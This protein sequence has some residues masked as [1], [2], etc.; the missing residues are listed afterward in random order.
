MDFDAIFKAYYSLYRTEA[1]VPNNQD[2]EYTV[3]LALA[4]EAIDRWSSYDN[5]YWKELFD[6]NLT[7]DNAVDTTV[8]ADTTDYDAPTDMFEASGFVRIKNGSTTVRRYPILDAQEAQMKS[9]SAYYAYFTGD[10]NNGFVLHLNPSVDAAIDGFDM[11]YDYYKT[12][13]LMTKGS[14]KPNMS[15]PYFIVHRMLANRFRGSRNPYYSTAKSD[16]EDV[17]RTM[18]AMNN[19]GSWANPWS[20]QDTSGTLFGS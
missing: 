1:D 5:T 12:P 2:D 10:P 18:Q 15:R 17:L 6:T 8:S 11:E 3:A 7:S 20:L 19:S 13:T 4:N 16:A 9:D 14:S